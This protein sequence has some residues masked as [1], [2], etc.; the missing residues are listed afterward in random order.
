MILNIRQ[1]VNDQVTKAV[2]SEKEKVREK[3]EMFDQLS[4]DLNNEKDAYRNLNEILNE[5]EALISKY[6]QNLRQIAQENPDNYELAEKI[7]DIENFR[8]DRIINVKQLQKLVFFIK[9]RFFLNFKIKK[10]FTK[11]DFMQ[12]NGGYFSRKQVI[13]KF[14]PSA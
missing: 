6:K 4:K 11:P 2:N 13:K 9:R 10:D 7:Q 3:L 12:S 14:G 1:Q 5:K 8:E